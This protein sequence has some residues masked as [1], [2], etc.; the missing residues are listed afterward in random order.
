MKS[1]FQHPLVH[2]LILGVLVAAAILI[3]RGPTGGDSEN[4]IVVTAADLIHLR[5]RFARTWQ[6]EPTDAELRN[7][8]EGH[9]RGEVLYHEALNRGYDRDDLVVRRAM[10]QKMEM[11]AQ[12]QALQ[13]PPSDDEVEA[14]FAMRR[15]H[16]R[17][18]A[19][20]TFNHV[21]LNPDEHGQNLDTVAAALLER[22]RREQPPA[23]ELNAWGDPI[24]LETHFARSTED[25]IG[26]TFGSEFADTVV[27]LPVGEWAGPVQSGYGLHLVRIT[28]LEASRLPEL[29]EVV[30]EV[31]ADMEYETGR[32]SKEVLFQEIAQTY[33]VVLDDTVRELLDSEQE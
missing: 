8:V 2:I 22:L 21:Y 11:L 20:I 29:D 28:E 24:M 6:R 18:P 3:V 10:Q 33:Q 13:T 31:L 16:Y 25:D 14:F 12:S 7:E 32:A 27:S 26:R 17:Q 9:I 19:V 23:M 1:L 4:R 5:A 30:S 15:E